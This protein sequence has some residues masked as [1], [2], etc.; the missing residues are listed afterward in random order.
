MK[1]NQDPYLICKIL[2]RLKILMRKLY[3]MLSP[4]IL[5]KMILT[6][7]VTNLLQ[8]EGKSK[9]TIHSL[10]CVFTLQNIKLKIVMLISSGKILRKKNLFMVQNNY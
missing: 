6:M 10:Q 5:A 7:K 3:L 9:I 4:L 2:N 8:K 1:S